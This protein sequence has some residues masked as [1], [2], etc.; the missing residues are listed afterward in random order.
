MGRS[1]GLPMLLVSLAIGG[2]LFASQMKA[3]GPTSPAVTQAETQAIQ[4]VASTN[5]SAA[6]E[7]LRA[8]FVE[9]DTY[10]GAAV[11]PSF[12]VTLVR[13]DAT[14]FCLQGGAGAAVMHELGPGGAPAAGL[15]TLSAAYCALSP[16]D[17]M[18]CGP[19]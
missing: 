17:L 7:F 8:Y 14:S 15:L 1:L 6:D 5:F 13:T 16:P 10:V 19:C 12:G 4:G 2:F 18:E 9:H 11:D 3:Q